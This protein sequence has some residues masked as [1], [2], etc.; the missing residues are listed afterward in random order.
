MLTLIRTFI[1]VADLGSFSKA[2]LVF[3]L[4][5]S[6][7]TRS[8]NKLETELNVR[9]FKRSTRALVLTEEGNQF[10]PRAEKLIEDADDLISS[11]QGTRSEP[12]GI[13]RISVFEGFGRAF[14]S[15]LLPEFLSR[16]PK[17][18]IEIELDNQIVDLNAENV[19]LG[20]RIGLPAD[21]SLNARLLLANKTLLCASP[22]YIEQHGMPSKPEDLGQH[23]CL[24]LNRD[25]QRTY[26][27]FRHSSARSN[28]ACNNSSKDYKK[29][30]VAGNLISKGGT[31]LL[32]AAVNHGGIVLLSSWMV[33][34]LITEG[35][36]V[37]CLPDWQG[38]LFEESSGVIY[39]VYQGNKYLKPSLRVFIDFLVE[40]L[41]TK[42]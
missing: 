17:L 35:K 36:L 8:I 2:A 26:W 40:K 4:A 10:Y 7:V 30:A 39:A 11:M 27:H 32:E 13:L 33:E 34:K 3:N 5:P 23:N 16:Y 20:I 41:S 42:L 14:I 6:S 18:K 19:D 24:I 9:L 29:I 31:P 1:K 25:R 38:S 12:E 15:P 28:R 37:Q 22:N 21:S